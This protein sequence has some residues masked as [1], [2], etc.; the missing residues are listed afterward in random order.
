M[1]LLLTLMGRVHRVPGQARSY[2]P[3]MLWATKFQKAGLS[4]GWAARYLA[5]GYEETPRLSFN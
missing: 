5:R 2:S 4:N 1:Q 3:M